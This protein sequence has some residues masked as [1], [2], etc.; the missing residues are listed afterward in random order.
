[1]HCAASER[2]WVR[3]YN[4]WCSA[5]NRAGRCRCSQAKQHQ[6]RATTRPTTLPRCRG[7]EVRNSWAPTGSWRHL[8]GG[9]GEMSVWKHVTDVPKGRVSVFAE[10]QSFTSSRSSCFLSLFKTLNWHGKMN[11]IYFFWIN[12]HWIS[13]HLVCKDKVLL[14]PVTSTALVLKKQLVTGY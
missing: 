9:D 12:Q 4:T 5:Y 2:N 1:M 3:A 7:R 13:Q 6:P 10:L 8:S 11:A 14:F